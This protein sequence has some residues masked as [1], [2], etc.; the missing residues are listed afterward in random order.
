M[1]QIAFPLGRPPLNFYNNFGV[2]NNL[3]LG[4]QSL[5]VQKLETTCS[6]ILK[7]ALSAPPLL[8]MIQLYCIY[9]PC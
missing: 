8:C 9:R 7:T 2:S 4:P 5:K 1:D 3:A 6:V